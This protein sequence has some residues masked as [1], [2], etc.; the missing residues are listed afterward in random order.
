MSLI[1]LLKGKGT[2]GFGYTSTAEE[3]SQGLD[4]TGQRILITGCTSGIGLESARTL[5][6]R[7]ATVLGAG[8]TREKAEAAMSA[9]A[10]PTV[11]L[12]CDLSEPESIRACVDTIRK[13]GEPID[14]IIA[15]AGIMAL[16]RARQKQ[17]VELQLF[18]N[19][20]GHFLL[21]TALLRQLSKTGR[22]V[23]VSST[24]HRRVPTIQ[25]DDLAFTKGYSPF[26]AYGQS[27]LANLLF[28]K[29]LARRFEDS[30]RVAIAVHPG[31]IATQLG[32]HM[33][34][35]M[36]FGLTAIGPFLKT[37]EQG[38]AT[39]VFAA[40]HPEAA[41]HNGAYLADCNPAVPTRSARDPELAAKLW[42]VSE[43]IAAQFTA[44]AT[45][46]SDARSI[47]SPP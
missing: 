13:Q 23:M 4:L 40:A 1:G 42:R 31:V 29:E 15:N 45:V 12:A 26:R 3:V 16:P 44:A 11:P 2:N 24:A 37:V 28:A 8:R 43:E 41:A 14:A 38:A 46:P 10:T 18:T 27:K 20:I 39:Q 32:R 34:A 47:G 9:F 25:F 35:V 6:L 33:N 22:V 21:I 30:Q 5:S 36:Q 19:H 7:G 17:G